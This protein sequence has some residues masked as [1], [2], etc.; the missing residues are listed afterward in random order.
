MAAAAQT[1]GT[2]SVGAGASLRQ[3]F[4][5]FRW[6]ILRTWLLVVL[7]A[8]LMLMFP[9]ALG[10]AIDGLL[11]GSYSGLALLGGLGLLTVLTGSVR[12]LYDTRV[13][14]RAYAA[15]G[16]GIVH[17]ERGSD[18]DV[19]VISA[20]TDMA[21]ELVEFFED[22]FPG[23]IDCVV[24]LVG[25][26]V[27]IWFLQTDVFAACLVAAACIVAVYA[28]TSRKTYLLNR[29]VNHESERRVRVLSEGGM[30]EVSAHFS[31]L[32]RWNIRLS[33]LETANFALSW[34]VMIVLLA[35]SV[36]ATVE[37]GVTGHG[38]V[39]AVIMYVFGF[40][41]SVVAAPLF[42][43]QYVRLQEITHRL[44]GGN[45]AGV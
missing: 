21:G 2:P 41:E 6:G 23:I 5:A 35:Y 16:A 12:R 20:R 28:A 11:A 3:V 37:G 22:S 30:P 36:A 40:I 26:L 45:G 9:L 25:A 38:K 17:R 8:V 33:D 39:L 31:R 14:A 29:G 42:Y 1:I 24:G 15:A 44:A 32:M 7:E 43:Q 13:Y 10:G 34:V 19:S 18:T 27:M 4:A